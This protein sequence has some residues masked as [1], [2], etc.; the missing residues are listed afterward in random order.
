MKSTFKVLLILLTVVVIS[1][2]ANRLEQSPLPHPISRTP[3]THQQKQ[4]KQVSVGS[5][6][7][8]RPISGGKRERHNPDLH[9]CIERNSRLAQLVGGYKRLAELSLAEAASSSSEDSR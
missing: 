4:Q 8:I 3:P 9:Q 7:R 5:H 2:V 6:V 1:I